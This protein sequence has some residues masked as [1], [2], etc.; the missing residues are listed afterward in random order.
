ML[1]CFKDNNQLAKYKDSYIISGE[2]K[3]EQVVLHQRESVILESFS[4]NIIMKYV[5]D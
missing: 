3:F 2:F 1:F 4:S 5:H